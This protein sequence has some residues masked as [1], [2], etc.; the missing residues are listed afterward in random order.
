LN[1][2][3]NLIFHS[4]LLSAIPY[5]SDNNDFPTD[6]IDGCGYRIKGKVGIYDATLG[7][8]RT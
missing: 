3:F 2:T 5:L 1:N 8:Y 4:K 6:P 7:W